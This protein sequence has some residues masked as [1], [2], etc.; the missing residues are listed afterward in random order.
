M[1]VC[2]RLWPIIVYLF[3]GNNAGEFWLTLSPLAGESADACACIGGHYAMSKERAIIYQLNIS[4]VCG[5]CVDRQLVVINADIF[6]VP[7]QKRWC[8]PGIIENNSQLS[9]IRMSNRFLSN[10]K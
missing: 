4:G 1:Y 3:P 8:E 6:A 9:E 5:R 2:V 10:V 7:T